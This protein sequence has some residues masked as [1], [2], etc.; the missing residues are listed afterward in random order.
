MPVRLVPKKWIHRILFHFDFGIFSANTAFLNGKSIQRNDIGKKKTAL[1][2][3]KNYAP[4]TPGMN[5]EKKEENQLN[6]EQLS[7]V[8]DVDALQ[9]LPDRCSS[10]AVDYERVWAEQLTLTDA[11]VNS[12]LLKRCYRDYYEVLLPPPPSPLDMERTYIWIGDDIVLD[13]HFSRHFDFIRFSF[14]TVI[15]PPEIFPDAF[16]IFPPPLDFDDHFDME[17]VPMESNHHTDDQL[18]RSIFEFSDS[19]QSFDSDLSNS[20]SSRMHFWCDSQPSESISKNQYHSSFDFIHRVF[21][22]YSAFIHIQYK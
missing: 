10:K 6:A 21:Y 1:G 20:F 15:T 8:G 2:D 9:N 7:L 18:N 13:G 22:C 11:E 4:M 5:C 3:I 17:S 16:D 14:H 12:I 19:D